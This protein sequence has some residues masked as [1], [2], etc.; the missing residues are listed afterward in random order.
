M[1]PDIA[2]RRLLTRLLSILLP[3][4]VLVLLIGV[5]IRLGDGRSDTPEATAANAA[6][7]PAGTPPG[8]SPSRR[9]APDPVAGDPLWVEVDIA[10]VAEPPPYA[11]EWSTQGRVLVRL[12]GAASAAGRWRL[13][14]RLALP[15]PQLGE[16]YRPV[17]EGIDD[18]PAARTFLARTAETDGR[19]RCIF[20]IGPSSVFAY[21]DTPRGPYE[22]LADHAFGWLVPSSSL[23]GSHH[24]GHGAPPAAAP[25]R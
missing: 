10:E 2:D 22:L 12:S 8:E 4:S 7:P 15:V 3:A 1:D 16:T 11:D 18:G 20:T 6:R 17:I 13:G 5:A 14:D 25:G 9:G 21:I 23:G 24:G 19:R